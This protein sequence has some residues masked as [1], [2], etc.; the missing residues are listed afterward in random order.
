[1]LATKDKLRREVKVKTA[2]KVWI[3]IAL[4]A[5]IG[6]VLVAPARA[7]EPPDAK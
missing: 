7:Q 3:G 6:S 4:V 1:M 2:I 5:V